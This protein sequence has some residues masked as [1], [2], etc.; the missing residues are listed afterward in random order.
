MAQK[1]NVQIEDS[2]GNTYH[3]KPDL[4]TSKEQVNANTAQ[5]K[6]VD[7]LVIKEIYNNL[8]NIGEAIIGN[9]SSLSV[10][11][12]VGKAVTK[13]TLPPGK[14]I[15]IAC[16][17]FSSDN[18]GVRLIN[19]YTQSG[20]SNSSDEAASQKSASSYGASA[21]TTVKYVS[22]GTATTYYLNAFQNSGST[23]SCKG[24]LEAVRVGL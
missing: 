15:L 5:G 12:G 2:T 4:L 21:L 9:G 14:Y 18:N 22:I 6:S 17:I 10:A 16:C 11:T 13:V 19:I 7:A 1:Y 8:G 23:L 24:T 3:P 20:Y